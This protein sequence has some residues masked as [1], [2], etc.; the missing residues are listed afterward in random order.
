V[1]VS[2]L[3]MV[4]PEGKS[5]SPMVKTGDGLGAHNGPMTSTLDAPP[6]DMNTTTDTTS[7]TPSALK[8]P[9]R[10]ARRHPGLAI[11][12]L[13][14]STFTL[15]FGLLVMPIGWYIWRCLNEDQQNRFSAWWHRRFSWFR[16]PSPA[17]RVAVI[18]VSVLI[19]LCAFSGIVVAAGSN[20][21]VTLPQ[22][23]ALSDMQ[24]WNIANY[25]LIKNHQPTAGGNITAM[26]NALIAADNVGSN[27]TVQGEVK[28]LILACQLGTGFF[29]QNG[30]TCTDHPVSNPGARS[31]YAHSNQASAADQQPA[32]HPAP[33]NNQ[34]APTPPTGP[35]PTGPVT[36]PGYNPSTKQDVGNVCQ[37]LNNGWSCPPGIQPDASG[38]AT[39]PPPGPGPAAVPAPAHAPST[40]YTDTPSQSGC[41]FTDHWVCP[42]GIQVD[43]AWGGN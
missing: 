20:K 37:W 2:W 43:P 28:G 12:V 29:V 32:A 10:W 8:T 13:I 9:F 18:A 36:V 6:A 41:N 17:R 15:G 21:P 42:P 30:G 7:S 26:Q 27:Y 39:N 4:S 3:A 33:T 16:T 25:Q 34:P 5:L 11:L 40:S 38:E 22:Y 23:A 31:D 24:Q 19:G 35:S 14:F 1:V